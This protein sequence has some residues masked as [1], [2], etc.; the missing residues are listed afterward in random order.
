MKDCVI[1]TIDVSG[2]NLTK[3]EIWKLNIL[4]GKV[5]GSTLEQCLLN[6]LIIKDSI[7]KEVF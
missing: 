1:E 4:S 2:L 5:Y 3:S 6:N 7:V